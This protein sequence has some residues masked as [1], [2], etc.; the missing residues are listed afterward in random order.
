MSRK[1][2]VIL[3]SRALAIMHLIFAIIEITYLPV[4]YMSFFHHA[5]RMSVLDTPT[6]D[7]YYRTYYGVD[8][9]LLLVRV[10]IEL[11]V[12]LLFWKCGPWIERILLPNFDKTD[13]SA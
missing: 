6:Y 11:T 1:D 5:N 4:R 8:I 10:A 7:A 3:I 2:T 12:A 13:H 9:A